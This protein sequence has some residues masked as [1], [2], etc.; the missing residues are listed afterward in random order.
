M[1]SKPG[2]RLGPDTDVADGVLER[3]HAVSSL[4]GDPG[5]TLFISGLAGSKD[6]VLSVGTD[7]AVV[8]WD[9]HWLVVIASAT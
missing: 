9:P 3:R 1:S 7:G 2:L 4:I 8:E 5:D 6:D